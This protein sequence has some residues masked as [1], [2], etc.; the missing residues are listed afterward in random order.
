LLHVTSFIFF[1]DENILSA[2]PDFG[3]AVEIDIH[4]AV[5][6]VSDF[7]SE[8]F[9]TTFTSSSL[10]ISSVKVHFPSKSLSINHFDN[11]AVSLLFAKEKVVL[12]HPTPFL[13]VSGL[14]FSEFEK[15]CKISK[16]KKC[17]EGIPAWKH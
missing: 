5:L 2:C 11:L 3:F 14:I 15:T 9:T 10:C 4:F 1:N 13:P 7:I 8:H 6:G 16:K 17:R 12:F